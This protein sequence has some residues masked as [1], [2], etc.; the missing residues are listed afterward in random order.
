MYQSGH[1]HPKKNLA[2]CGYILD[3][4]V[5]K[6]T[7]SF[8]IL[9]CLLKLIITMSQFGIFSFKPGKFVSFFSHEKTHWIGCNQNFWLKFDKYFQ[10][11]RH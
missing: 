5:E 8:Y 1:G 9:G 6:K 2:K 3:M 7:E 4:K 10:Q 11:E